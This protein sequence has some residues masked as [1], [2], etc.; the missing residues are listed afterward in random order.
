M[1]ISLVPPIGAAGTYVLKAPF[2]SDIVADQIYTC[3]AI[4]RLGE[5][6]LLGIDPFTQYYE[7]KEITASQY[8]LD[9]TQGDVCIVSLQSPSGQLAFVPS[10]YI[11]SYPN[12]NGHRYTPVILAVDIGSIPDVLQLSA[13]RTA[14]ADIVKTYLGINSVSI[15]SIAVGESKMVSQQDHNALEA[16]RLGRVTVTKTM[17]TQI[18]ELQALNASLTARNQELENYVLTHTP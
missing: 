7:P 16:A 11:E 15:T 12:P 3:V 4:R 2:Q 10:T 8:E 17:Y 14:V 18:Q 1:S 13:M 9:V 5:F 6:R